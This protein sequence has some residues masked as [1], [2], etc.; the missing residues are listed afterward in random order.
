MKNMKFIKSFSKGQI[1]VPLEIR[2]YLGL[3]DE[4]WLK[5]YTEGNRIVAEPVESPKGGKKS[6]AELLLSLDTACFD[7]KYV[8]ELRKNRV[9]LENRVV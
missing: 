2:N 4:F 7:E 9:D 3:G 8:G 5:L 1:T 6:L